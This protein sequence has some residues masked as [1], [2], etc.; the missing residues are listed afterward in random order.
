MTLCGILSDSRKHNLPSVDPSLTRSLAGVK[1]TT[2]TMPETPQVPNC[3]PTCLADEPLPEP[4]ALADI[5]DPMR[6]LV[7]LSS[8]LDTILESMHDPNLRYVS[9]HDLI[10]A[11]SVLSERIRSQL[12]VIIHATHPLPALAPLE[13]HASVLARALTR[14]IR[15]ALIDPSK[16]RETPPSGESSF[17][18]AP[19]T[20][21]EIQYALDL[22]VLCHHALRFVSDVFAFKP[23]YSLFSGMHRT[24]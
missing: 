8:P 22:A 2:Q 19:M 23:L 11:Y 12:R 4:P 1:H 16:L 6:S 14:D 24:G 9:L 10:E 7:Y 18:N 15:R 21:H 13:E 5:L 17:T 20:D 3:D